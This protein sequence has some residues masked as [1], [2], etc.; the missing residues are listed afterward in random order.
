[1]PKDTYFEQTF[2]GPWKGINVVMPENMLDASSSPSML[3]MVL[4]DGEI[5]TRQRQEFLIPAPSKDKILV[6]QSFL[7]A[8]QVTHTIIV[9][10][11]GMYQLNPKWRNNLAQ[12]WNLVGSFPVSGGLEIPVSHSTYLDKFF[13]TNGGSNLWMWDGITSVGNPSQWKANTFYTINTKVIDSNGKVEI[14]SQAGKSGS[15]EPS[16]SGT[17][18]NPTTDGTVIWTNYGAPA[19]SNGFESVAVV[20]ATNGITAGGFFMG[21]LNAHLMLLNTNEG[22]IAYPQRIRWAA[23]GY[24]NIWDPSVNVGAGY[25]DEI[26]VPSIISGFLTIGRVGF[27]FRDNGITE[28]TSLSSGANPFDFNHLWASDNG[29]GNVFP[30]SIAGYGPVGMFISEDDIYNL[31][32]GGFKRVGA[33][34]RDAI[35]A[36]IASATGQPVAAILPKISRGYA[37]PIYKLMIPF[38]DGT[39]IWNYSI[40]DDS[41]Q[42]DFKTFGN[43]TGRP[44]FVAT[45]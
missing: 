4:K 26:D 28:M 35:Y 38:G 42:P 7:D 19:P 3:N 24:T 31:T 12:A 30:F 20:D 43:F 5:R 23:S 32:L 15:S 37:Y 45:Y 14:V 1:M 34:A 39:K 22:G 41:W 2:R 33:A 9:N 36:D 11:K 16:W 8:N 10:K 29:I 17:I 44:Q 18:S 27:V 40:E 21:V 6:V 13:W 25:N